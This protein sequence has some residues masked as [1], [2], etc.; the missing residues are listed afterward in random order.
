MIIL[1]GRQREVLI[2]SIQITKFT[3]HLGTKLQNEEFT[4][5]QC[6]FCH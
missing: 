1:N 6:K 4:T 3:K 5:K 2:F